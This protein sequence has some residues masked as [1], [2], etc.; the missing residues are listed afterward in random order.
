MIYDNGSLYEPHVLDL[1]DDDILK[2]FHSGVRNLACIS[3]QVGIPTIASLPHS[4]ARGYKNVL[5]VA[6]ATEYTFPGA[7]KI[8]QMLANPSAFATTAPVTST[9]T[10]E[11]KQ[12]KDEPKG[13]QET[14]EPEEEEDVGMG[15]LFD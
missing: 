15:G 11:T 9:P 10:K 8:K 1:S 14:K 12:P 2:K 13:K 7:D 4:L 6:L 3:L 5:A